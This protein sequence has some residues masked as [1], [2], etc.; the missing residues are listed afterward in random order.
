MNYQR[1]KSVPSIYQPAVKNGI[2]PIVE[3]EDFTSSIVLINTSFR[4]I[5]NFKVQLHLRKD[6]DFKQVKQRNL[7]EGRSVS[8]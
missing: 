6:K 2:R 1:R 5:F 7:N 8:F 4:L 3:T